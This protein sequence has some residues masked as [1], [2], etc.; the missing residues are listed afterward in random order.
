MEQEQG[1]QSPVKA[2]D[3]NSKTEQIIA[4]IKARALAA[5]HSSPEQSPVDLDNLSDSS[6]T[7]SEEDDD[8]RWN[9]RGQLEGNDL[10][11]KG[12]TYVVFV[13]LTCVD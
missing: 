13:A 2:L 11:R 1:D 6:S 12:N 4:E 7:S 8:P 9:L 5:V 10:K 3:S